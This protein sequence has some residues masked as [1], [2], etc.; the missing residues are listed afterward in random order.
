MSISEAVANEQSEPNTEI[1]G[2]YD[3]LSGSFA[4]ACRKGDAERRPTRSRPAVDRLP[5]CTCDTINWLLRYCDDERL[6]KF[7]EGRPEAELTKIK[8]HIAWKKSQ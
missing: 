4:E 5:T 8:N 1:R 6:R 3:R 2:D 7:L